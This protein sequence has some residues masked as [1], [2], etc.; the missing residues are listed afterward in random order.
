MIWEEIYGCN[1]PIEVTNANVKKAAIERLMGE[2]INNHGS[3]IKMIVLRIGEVEP[4]NRVSN[5]AIKDPH[6]EPLIPLERVWWHDLRSRRARWHMLGTISIASAA[7]ITVIVIIVAW[8]VV[9]WCW[10]V[11]LAHVDGLAWE[12]LLEIVDLALHVV[13]C[14]C[15]RTD[16]LFGGGVCGAESRDGAFERGGTGGSCLV[17]ISDGVD[18]IIISCRWS[19][20]GRIGNADG[21]LP[22]N[23]E[24]CV[25]IAVCVGSLLPCF[26]FLRVEATVLNDKDCSIE[27]LMLLEWVLRADGVCVCEEEA[28]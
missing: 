17:I 25:V 5:T 18:A 2:D 21:L 16:T 6:D 3:Y 13:D 4:G 15:L 24:G 20:D 11:L 23:F 14:I 10:V 9:L 12:L 1:A 27:D 7:L 22:K 8:R 19:C 28:M 26:H